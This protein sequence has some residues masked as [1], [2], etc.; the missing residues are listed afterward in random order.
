MTCDWERRFPTKQQQMEWLSYYLSFYKK[1]K[2]GDISAS[3]IK[4]NGCPIKS[5]DS[6]TSVSKTVGNNLTPDTYPEGI[7]I[8]KIRTE[9]LE[10]DCLPIASAVS[11]SHNSKI[12]FEDQLGENF[13]SESRDA[14]QTNATTRNYIQSTDVELLWEEVQYYVQAS[15]L[16][17]ACW[18][19][20]Q[21]Q[22]SDIP[23]DFLSY[24]I[25]RL[26]GYQLFK[27]KLKIELL[28]RD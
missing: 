11:S 6:K 28:N 19:L 22:L 2:S 5:T 9:F 15:H 20:H 4:S 23:F 3:P 24:A 1:I 16:F 7:S 10:P 18:A 17:W 25:K 8:P 21:T 12:F 27:E 14:S 13:E 26:Q